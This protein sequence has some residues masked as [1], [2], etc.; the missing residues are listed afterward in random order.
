MNEESVALSRALR[1][2]PGVDTI[3][4]KRLNIRHLAPGSQVGRF[5]I[6]TESAFRELE[7]QFGS[8]KAP[9]SG[10]KHYLLKKEVIVNSDISGI[11]NSD[12]V[13]RVLRA[14]KTVKPIHYKQKKN[15]LRNKGEMKKLN[16][17]A[18]ILQAKKAKENSQKVKKIRKVRK[19]FTSKSG[20]L[21]KSVEKK[22]TEVQTTQNDEYKKLMIESLTVSK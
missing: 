8:L 14:K 22:I 19:A 11:I 17:F 4:V 13:Q 6:Y 1:N 12:E 7:N 18:P 10:R 20:E 5:A 9:G 3:N 16:P 2:I 21:I 15:P